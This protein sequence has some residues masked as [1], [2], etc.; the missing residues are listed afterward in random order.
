MG[1]LG[2]LVIRIGA[3][4]KDFSTEMQ[5]VER[6]LKS[7]GRQME[8]IGSK[9]SV[10]ITAPIL[11]LGTASVM[12]AADM[13]SLMLGLEATTGSAE[14]AKAEFEKLREV[15]KLPGIGLEEAVRGSINLQAIG[16]SAD[17]AR[18]AMMS[19]GNAI[20][21]IGGGKENFDLAIRG[22]SQLTNASKPLQQDL[23]QIANQ[24]PQ[25]NKLM[26]DAF[27]TNRAEDL[28]KLGL[29]GRQLAD[30]L[31]TELGKLPTVTGGIKV[32]FENLSDSI[33]ISMA[34]IGSTIAQNLDLQGI[35]DKLSGFLTRLAEGFAN[36]SPGLQKFIL[37]VI[38]V[39]AALGPLLVIL[40]AVASAVAAISIPIALVVAAVATAVGLI[41]VYWD[42][43]VSYFEGPGTGVWGDVK[44]VIIAAYEVVA[45]FIGMFVDYFSNLW[46]NF[47]DEIMTVAQGVWGFIV[48]VFSAA[49]QILKNILNIF[50]GIFT[51]DWGL[52]WNSVQNI[53][54][55]AVNGVINI[56]TG[57]LSWIVD[58]FADFLEFL[59]V[60][61]DIVNSVRGASKSVDEFGESMKFQ[62]EETKNA[63]EELTKYNKEV[64]KIKKPDTKSTTKVVT[65][66]GGLSEAE[67]K[68]IHDK[69]VKAVEE[70]YEIERQLQENQ[71]LK[72]EITE[73]QY[74]EN[75][76][77][78]R[79]SEIEALLKIEKEGS[80]AF[81]KLQN[82]K[83]KILNSS[84]A[85]PVD[86]L[87]I[88]E[89]WYNEDEAMLNQSL[90]NKEIS[91][92]EHSTR[93]KELRLREINEL[94]ALEKFGSD[95]Y[96]QLQTEQM[97]IQEELANQ[98]SPLQ[99]K[100]KEFSQTVSDSIKSATAD[101]LVGAAEMLGAALT[102][103]SGLKQIPVMLLKTLGGLMGQVGKAAIGIGLAMKGIKLSF[104][105]PAGAITAGIALIAASAAL[106]AVVSQMG[107]SGGDA[108]ALAAGGLAFGPTLAMVGDNPMASRNP[109]VI[110][111]L[112]K[113]TGMIEN[114]QMSGEVVFRI[115]GTEL[116]GVLRRE[117][118]KEGR[119][120]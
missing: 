9:M 4:L 30:F 110:A 7:V 96:L 120:A 85:P 103:G 90:M 113:L 94:L 87:K 35:F 67:L 23:Y 100:F 17:D 50:K 101:F 8:S 77:N 47:G 48:E 82:E 33:K 69:A 65:G 59:G 74:A 18:K 49:M 111:P 84:V 62:V 86:S 76:R 36:L 98:L 57:L 16:V 71:L 81:I 51:G 89:D 112:S 79:L 34:K 119:A 31:V 66:G 22:F 13:E 32:G 27:G 54:K 43:L 6:Q 12:A 11:A 41:I 21:T 114:N 40:G 1:I 55:I 102:T 83:L 28:A 24:L 15:A 92:A 5:N 72:K 106:G 2:S 75:L 107:K 70:R 108:P 80:S 10:G 64:A 78:I 37:V 99:Q 117:Q 95:K 58:A 63:T 26:I 91:Q 118:M 25:V 29:S 88:I 116:V 93:M 97:R 46:A 109:E 60:G 52:I 3:D 19:F 105:N 14:A 56:I 39:V 38:G 53:L 115:S 61:D 44:D 42:D 104:A 73:Q 45:S 20:A 68:K